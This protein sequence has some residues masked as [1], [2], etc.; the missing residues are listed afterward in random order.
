MVLLIILVILLLLYIQTFFQ[1][2]EPILPKPIVKDYHP[3][4]NNHSK[5]VFFCK[6]N[7]KKIVTQMAFV[8]KA[9]IGQT[10]ATGSKS[11]ANHAKYDY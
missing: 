1:L 6:S 11:I 9:T 2:G 4:I 3:F 8:Q 7:I 10:S 5:L